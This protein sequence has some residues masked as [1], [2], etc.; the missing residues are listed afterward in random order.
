MTT[1][2]FGS[3]PVPAHNHPNGGG[4]VA[5]TAY[6]EYTAYIGP[7]AWVYDE[8]RVYGTARVYENARVSGHARVYDNAQVCD[9]AHV[10]GE[11]RVYGVAW[12]YGEARVY[13]EARVYGEALVYGDAQVNGDARVS[14]TP[15]LITRS[16][17]YD[18]VA[19]SCA[20]GQ[21]RVIAGCRYFTFEE[22]Y[23]HWT[24]TR[25]GTPLGEESIDILDALKAQIG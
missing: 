12:V 8:A 7:N 24:A 20:D 19:V 9:N 3:G 14:V 6:V 10:S 18:F 22:A 4:W 1:F 13:D 17:G 11:A 21:V 16:D 25:G 2:D 15:L 5:D 23:A